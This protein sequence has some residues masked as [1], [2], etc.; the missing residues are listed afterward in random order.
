MINGLSQLRMD[1]K[2][3][4]A[5]HKKIYLRGLHQVGSIQPTQLQRLARILKLCMYDVK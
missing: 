1:A 3:T 2:Y 5:H 4:G